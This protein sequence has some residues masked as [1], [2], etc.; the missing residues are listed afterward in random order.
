MTSN[1]NE[2][3]NSRNNMQLFIHPNT[4]KLDSIAKNFRK[5]WMGKL[6]AQGSQGLKCILLFLLLQL[7]CN[8]TK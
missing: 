6:G 3:L 4:V 7:L 8:K 1:Y 2:Y 5:N